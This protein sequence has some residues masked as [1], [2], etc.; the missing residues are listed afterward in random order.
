MGIMEHLFF[1]GVDL[2]DFGALLLIGNVFASA[3]RK[4]DTVEVPGRNGSLIIAQGGYENV[5]RTYDVFFHRE[6]AREGSARMRSFLT[7]RTGYKRIE[8]TLHPDEFVFGCFR[9]GLDNTYTENIKYVRYSL[10][11]DCKP[12]RFLKSGEQT[13]AFAA[14]G[15]LVNPE[16]TEALPLVC[17]L[18]NGTVT[19]NGRAVTVTGNADNFTVIDSEIQDAYRHS[20]NRNGYI[21]LEDG[22]FPVLKPGENL[23][24]L[25]AGI[26]CV[27]IRP[28]WWRL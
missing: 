13:R 20:E 28:R 25:G 17:V 21:T 3:A 6:S 24:E 16:E 10:S 23:V 15:V 14:D 4:Y 18:G 19:V 8:D 5:I 9:G 22:E 2:A 1:D 7:T 12:Q 27:E 11:F 26:A